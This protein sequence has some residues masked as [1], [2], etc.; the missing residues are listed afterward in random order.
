MTGYGKAERNFSGKRIAIEV[1]SLNSKQGDIFTR[2]PPYYKEKELEI[3]KQI[4]QQLQRGKIEFNIYV[5]NFS[6]N[7]NY[8]INKELAMKYFHELKPIAEATGNPNFKDFLPVLVKMP[9]V[10]VNEN[11]T[12]DKEEWLTVSDGI[13]ECLNQVSDYRRS[14]GKELEKDFMLRVDNIEKLLSEIPPF[15][16][17]RIEKM[18]EKLRKDLNEN[19]SDSQFDKNRFE[20]ELI[21]YLE[22]FDIT[23]EKVRLN[24]H[25]EYFRQTLNAPESSGKKLNFISQEIG[26]EINTIGSKANHT[27]I[28]HLVVAMKDELEKIKEQL[29]NIL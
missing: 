29:S 15:E 26:R 4:T 17:V 12:L 9:D 27:E 19:L 14:E 24:N 21:Y 25:C 20:Q 22:K 7:S 16:E 2:I 10:L 18:K 8:S 11:T 23:E 5:E 3:R 13:E 28:Q 6:A 1:K